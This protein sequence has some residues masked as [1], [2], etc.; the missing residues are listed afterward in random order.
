MV[1][2]F[3]ESRILRNPKMDGSRTSTI[4]VSWVWMASLEKNQLIRTRNLR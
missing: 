3:H 4:Q 1:T 2:P